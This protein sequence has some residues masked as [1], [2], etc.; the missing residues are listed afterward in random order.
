MGFAVGARE[1]VTDVLGIIPAGRWRG[2]QV[3]DDGGRHVEISAVAFLPQLDLKDMRR[4][5]IDDL[6]D[7][8]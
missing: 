5:I 2:D 8:P 6:L 7:Q 4:R 3:Y 1:G